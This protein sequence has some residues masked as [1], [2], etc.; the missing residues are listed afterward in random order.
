M[1]SIFIVLV[2]SFSA[3]L[4]ACGGMPEMPSVPSV[5]LPE[6]GL[7]SAPAVPGT[8]SVT[9]AGAPKK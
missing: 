7:P 6:A 5:G 4:L 2:L 8:G 1:R 3:S 9:D